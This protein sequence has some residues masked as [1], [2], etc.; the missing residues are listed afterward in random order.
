M[1]A[2]SDR[3]TVEM[4][5]DVA[6]VRLTDRKI[7]DEEQIQILGAQLFQL[8]EQRNIN[9]IVLSF[10]DVEYYSSAGLGKLITLNKKVGTAKGKIV[11]CAM[12]PEIREVF[13]ITH[14]D[15][16]FNIEPTEPKALDFM[17]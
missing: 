2:Q 3:F 6:L 7:L 16:F 1:T 12:I 10:R 13:N 9:Q 17:S 8:V 11:F 15:K 4:V 14:L 5:G